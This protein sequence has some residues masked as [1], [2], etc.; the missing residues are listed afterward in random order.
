MSIDG[1][2]HT[3]FARATEAGCDV[4]QVF[5]KNHRQWRAKPLDDEAIALWQAAWAAA[6][7]RP[8]SLTTAT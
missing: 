5:V 8:W 1:G 3:A 4:M 2:L 6:G 7:F